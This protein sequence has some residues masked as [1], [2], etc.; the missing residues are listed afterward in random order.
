MFPNGD[1]TDTLTSPYGIRRCMGK[2][3]KIGVRI[4]GELWERFKN[5]VEQEHGRTR[6][7]TA[8]EVENALRNHLAAD[9]PRDPLARIENDVA[10]IKAQLAES[11]GGEVVPEPCGPPSPSTT[12]THTHTDDTVDVDDEPTKP[13]S[14][15]PKSEKA[16]YLFEDLQTDGNIIVPPKVIDKRVSSLWG[17]GD[18]ATDDIR[19]IIFERYHAEAVSTD[20]STW[21]VA[22]GRT[23]DA[24]DDGIAEWIDGKGVSEDDVMVVPESKFDGFDKN[25]VPNGVRRS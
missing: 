20:G 6:G 5:W 23:E 3:K 17:F 12:D 2:K 13:G 1:F 19:S 9:N 25:D 15:A 21:E 24:R 11:D 18:R 14:K 22:L 16:E 8:D 10:T 4:D 7:V